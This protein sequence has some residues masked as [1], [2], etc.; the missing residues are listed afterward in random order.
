MRLVLRAHKTFFIT[1]ILSTE[2]ESL[3]LDM[4]GG[5]WWHNEAKA[6]NRWG[7]GTKDTIN[8]LQIGRVDKGGRRHFYKELFY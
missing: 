4:I 5:Q 7:F 6:V 3:G 1:K 8:A 2:I